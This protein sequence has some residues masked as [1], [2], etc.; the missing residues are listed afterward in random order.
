MHYMPDHITAVQGAQ[1]LLPTK[2]ADSLGQYEV[3]VLEKDFIASATILKSIC[4]HGT[5]SQHVE[6]DARNPEF[7][8]PGPPIVAPI[9]DDG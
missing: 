8:F 5:T 9:E 3:S 1:A 6:S 4:R 2:H 7:K